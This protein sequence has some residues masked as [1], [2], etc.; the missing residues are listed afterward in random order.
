[1]DLIYKTSG[2]ASEY[3][4]YALNHYIGCTC[5]C[6]Y[7]YAPRVMHKSPKLYHQETHL[8][9]NFFKNFSLEVYRKVKNGFKGNVLMSFVSD[10][11]QKI[12]ENEKNTRR[13]IRIFNQN[14]INF[15]V[16]SKNSLAARDFSFY[17]PDDWFA[18]T[19]TF[20]SDRICR[21]WEPNASPYTDRV[22]ALKYA[23][24]MKIKT[25]VSLEPVLSEDEVFKIIDDTYKWV[26]FYRLGPLNYFKHIFS[27]SERTIDFSPPGNWG[28]FAEKLIL[29]SRTYGKKIIFKNDA[30][31][32]ISFH[33]QDLKDLKNRAESI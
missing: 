6:V 15:T 11:Y 32:L 14:N 29:K 8:R 22:S 18:T 12:E 16:L 5:G 9:N 24:S 10:P 21:S 4:E 20:A 31:K 2:K 3:S 26:D 27:N 23:H 7:C 17:K 33:V 25:W 28:Q 30:M 19:L 1:M 13:I